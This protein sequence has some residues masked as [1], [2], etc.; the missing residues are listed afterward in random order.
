MS[1]DLILVI[2]AVSAV[3]T[4]IVSI[5]Y[6]VNFS[7]QQ[8]QHNR[9]SVRPICEIKIQDYENKI[10]VGIANVGTGP[11]TIKKIVCDD[12]DNNRISSILL[13]LMPP[14]SQHW[15]TFTGDITGRT[16][17]VGGKIVLIEINP[18]SDE[19]RY[20]LRRH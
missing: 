8:M 1:T 15:T 6:T 9:N 16:I 12:N 5:I 14:I 17:R 19:I 7:K 11:L 18:E 10:S 20:R 2:A 4:S 13:S 3:I